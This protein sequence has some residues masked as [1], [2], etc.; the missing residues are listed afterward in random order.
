MNSTGV[1]A[2]LVVVVMAVV[3]VL[4]VAA[5]VWVIMTLNRLRS[6]GCRCV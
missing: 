6:M 2:F 5:T 1:P 3:W 4:P